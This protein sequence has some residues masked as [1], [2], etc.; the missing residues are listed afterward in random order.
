MYD[1]RRSLLTNTYLVSNGMELENVHSAG[2]TPEFAGI[3]VISWS[4]IC[5]DS[6]I[7]NY[8]GVGKL[9]VSG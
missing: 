2:W 4:D 1:P 7:D 5:V 8:F 3:G 6:V 9:Q